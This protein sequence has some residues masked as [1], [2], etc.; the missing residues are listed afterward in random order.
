MFP[1]FRYLVAALGIDPPQWLG[2]FKTFGLLVALAFI[3]AA[4]TL[5][6]ELRRKEAEGL[7]KAD[8]EEVT[9]GKKAAPVQVLINTVLAFLLGYKIGGI[10]TDYDRVMPDAMSYL[11][12]G[13]GNLLVGLLAAAANL[14]VVWRDNQK[15]RN[16]TPQ[17]KKRIVHPHDRMS[18]ILTVAAVAGFA[19][20][21]IFNAFE[22]WD[23]FIANPASLLASAGFT[24]YGGLIVAAI[25]MYFYVRKR[26]WDFRHFCDATAPGLILAYGIG[27]LGCQFAGDGD[28]GIINSAYVTAADGSLQRTEQPQDYKILLQA[29]P[30]FARDQA[31]ND[32]ITAKFL[33][34]PA[35]L[36]RWA[37]AMNYP[38]NVNN[39]GVP[40]RD[41]QGDYCAVLPVA[42]FPT[43]IYESVMGIGIFLLLWALRKRIRRPLHLF[44]L[45][46]VLNGLERFMVEGIRVNYKYDWGALHPSQAEIIAVCLTLGGAVI[47]LFYRPKPALPAGFV[48]KE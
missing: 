42:V 23:N 40:L 20:A 33:P 37:V 8:L 19:G 46:L 17:V 5:G 26:G 6:M 18:Q 30:G 38:K 14:Y 47:L 27:R 45:Y 22:S 28:W 43:P 36:P 48:G 21:K 24:F 44:G 2:L 3:A 25:A 39:I 41:C 35:G 31:A 32:S 15:L 11:F 4:T 9:V 29:A 12:S 16:V 34:A 13:S 10:V 1:D 7:F